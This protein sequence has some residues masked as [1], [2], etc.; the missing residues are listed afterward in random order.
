MAD[1]K[2]PLTVTLDWQGDLRFSAQSGKATF[3][4]DGDGQAA[5][6]PMQTLAA[7]L[8]GCMAIDVVHILT[9]A[10]MPPAALEA[11]LIGHRANGQPAR[12][13]RFELRFVVKGAVAEAQVAR[14]I[15]LSRETYC[16]VWHSLRSDI[17]LDTSFELA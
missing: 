3:A 9:K 5:P 13:E 17:T 15:A 14:A 7:S 11:R 4:L 1:P 8:A 6:S 10:R 2:P 12:F 16:S